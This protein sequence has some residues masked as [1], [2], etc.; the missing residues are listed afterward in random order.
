MTADLDIHPASPDEL[1]AAHRN[2][3]DIWSKGLSLEEHLRYRLDSPSH[4]RATWF[5]GCVAGQVVASLGCYPLDFRLAGEKVPGIAIGSV[6]TLAEFRGRGYAP[7]LLNWVEQTSHDKNAELSVLYSDIDPGYYARL[8]YTLCP[9]WAGWCNPR[10]AAPPASEYQLMPV[11]PLEQLPMLMVLYDNYHGA[12]PLSVAREEE[13]WRALLKKYP[14]DQFYLFDGPHGRS[15]G[16]VRVGRKDATWR[17]TD[18][19]LADRSEERAGQLYAA[20]VGLARE[21]QVARLGGWLP[22]GPAAR[23][24][25][26]IA[27]RRAEITM[28]KPLGEQRSLS[29][30]AI[31]AASWFCEIDHV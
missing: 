3:F 26:A 7:Q 25:F 17:I 9:S 31:A 14:D 28:I 12:M 4:R 23:D 19:A 29:G 1:I 10:E 30:E 13:Y 2:V 16:Y 24:Y 8:G 11:S 21:H 27:P 6:Y 5:V 22:E 15:Q 20:L 18:F